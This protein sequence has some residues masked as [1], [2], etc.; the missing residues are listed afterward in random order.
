[1]VVTPVLESRKVKAAVGDSLPG[2]GTGSRN[3]KPQ[4]NASLSMN[5]SQT[6]VLDFNKEPENNK[7][8]SI[9]NIQAK[10]LYVQK[11]NCSSKQKN[12]ESNGSANDDQ[13][14]AKPEES[15]PLARGLIG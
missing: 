15:E 3:D 4:V 9:S 1:M 13:D 14:T 5:P 6:Q 7:N 12:E 2:K 8:E 10:N 11:A